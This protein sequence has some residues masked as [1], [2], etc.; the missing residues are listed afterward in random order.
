MKKFLL[1]L[2]VVL[3]GV[4]FCSVVNATHE[5]IISLGMDDVYFTCKDQYG[6][7]GSSD[8]NYFEVGAPPITRIVVSD[9]RERLDGIRT[10]DVPTSFF[11][12]SAGVDK[13]DFPILCSGAERFIRLLERITRVGVDPVT[14]Q[15][16]V[17]DITGVSRAAEHEIYIPS[18]GSRS[19]TTNDISLGENVLSRGF[20]STP[21]DPNILQ[22]E[23]GVYRFDY[24]IIA[25]GRDSRG[26]REIEARLLL[27]YF[28]FSD[29]PLSER[30][31]SSEDVDSKDGY[32]DALIETFDGLLGSM[33]QG[34][35]STGLSLTPQ[36]SQ[37][38]DFSQEPSQPQLSDDDLSFCQ[39]D[40][41]NDGR[42]N[43]VDLVIVG[44]KFG[45]TAF[46]GDPEDV[47]GDGQVNIVDLVT[48]GRRFG[49][50]RTGLSCPAS[51]TTFSSGQP[52]AQETPASLLLGSLFSTI[53]KIVWGVV[54]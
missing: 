30:I 46:P 13:A 18:G 9:A 2:L 7:M 25:Q 21:T 28:L 12:G 5:S 8:H 36:Q 6:N 52:L 23:T 51:F 31:G 27:V 35:D 43:I 38:F 50:S 11:F 48:V 44:R 33:E 49:E 29:K 15:Y 17:R 22:A 45:Q 53:G 40:I 54:F 37:I 34:G 39:A 41:N 42:V 10:V 4:S 32:D 26:N 19:E 14:G 1:S 3:V 16:S 20:V 47:N 24:R